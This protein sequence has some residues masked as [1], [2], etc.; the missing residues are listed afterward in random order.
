MHH[1]R[2]RTSL[3]SP[4]SDV[5]MAMAARSASPASLKNV[6]L[7]LLCAAIAA[8]CL[9]VSSAGVSLLSLTCRRTPHE[10]LCISILESD[11]RSDD[12]GS[13]QQLAFIALTV[14][15]N[16]TRDTLRRATDLGSRP[17][18]TPLARELL[19][20]C[21]ALYSA[22]LRDTTRA[23]ASVNAGS[24]ADADGAARELH[25]YPEKCEGLFSARRIRSPL[26]LRNKYLQEKLI[27][28]ADIVHLL[29]EPRK[30]LIS[31]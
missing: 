16:S 13:V 15:R 1:I 22:S 3:E 23:I 9:P 24:Y 31:N 7:A 17:R 25:G 21:A 4:N 12:A 10:R 26:E 20:Q 2:T 6:F 29:T 28:S 5:A 27:A 11:R 8:S 14:A 18:T 19:A 30:H